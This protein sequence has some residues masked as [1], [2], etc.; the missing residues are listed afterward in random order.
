M[1]KALEAEAIGQLRQCTTVVRTCQLRKVGYAENIRK[2]AAVT[3]IVIQAYGFPVR[4]TKSGSK[5]GWRTLREKSS[6]RARDGGTGK[7][8]I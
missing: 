8:V 1:K 2:K 6:R 4:P 5:K 7:R 3:G